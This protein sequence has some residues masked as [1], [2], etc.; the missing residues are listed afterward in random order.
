MSKNGEISFE[1]LAKLWESAADVHP[2]T[3]G[4]GMASMGTFRYIA[5][6]YPEK[7]LRPE[8]KQILDKPAFSDSCIVEFVGESIWVIE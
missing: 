8:V 4:S 2:S 5:S 7:R 6:R 3:P 1:L